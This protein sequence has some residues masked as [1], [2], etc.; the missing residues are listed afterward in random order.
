MTLLVTILSSF[1]VTTRLS[2]DPSPLTVDPTNTPTRRDARATQAI[3]AI[4][5]AY[6]TQDSILEPREEWSI[7]SARQW[8]WP[9]VHD[10]NGDGNVELVVETSDGI[11][12]ANAKSG[13]TIW[14]FDFASSGEILSSD[15]A[16][17]DANGDGTSDVIVAITD[18]PQDKDRLVCINGGTGEL[19]WQKQNG[20][21]ITLVAAYDIMGDADYELLVG[22]GNLSC[23]DVS[24]GSV[25]WT[26]LSGVWLYGN[27]VISD[28][29]GDGWT[30]IYVPTENNLYCLGYDGSVKWSASGG[31]HV[32]QGVFLAD[33]DEDGEPELYMLSDEIEVRRPSSGALVWSI[34]CEASAIVPGDVDGDGHLEVIASSSKTVYCY[35]LDDRGSLL[36]SRRLTNK[37][38][39]PTIVDVDGDGD[40]DVVV[41]ESD[42]SHVRALDGRSGEVLWDLNDYFGIPRSVVVAPRGPSENE[43]YFYLLAPTSSDGLV[44]L[45]PAT[46]GRRVFWQNPGGVFDC[47]PLRD[48]S[49]IDADG[50]MMSARSEVTYGTDLLDADTDDD[51]LPDGWEVSNQLDPLN[52]SDAGDDPDGDGLANIFEYGNCTDPTD[53]DTDNDGMP[54]GW[55]LSNRLD[56]LN[57]EDANDDNDEDELTNLEEYQLGTNPHSWDTDGDLMSDS[58]EVANNLNPLVDDS[59]D[60]PDNDGATNGDEYIAGTDP[61]DSDTDDDGLLDGWEMQYVGLDPLQPGQGDED[62]DSDGLTNLQ[63]QDA[64]TNPNR[65]DTDNDHC[66]DGWE[67]AHDLDPLDP[68]DGAEDTDSDGLINSLEY[69]YG[70]DPRD[71]DTD[72]DTMPDGWEVQ[73]GLDPT[74]PTV[75]DADGDMLDDSQEFALGSLPN[76]SDTDGDFAPDGLE[77]MISLSPTNPND[78]RI[79]MGILVVVMIGVVWK[80]RR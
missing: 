18:Q 56:P 68:D 40:L 3:P 59:T 37:A 74:D 14:T 10:L 46:Y 16:M 58:W 70:T 27:P 65:P 49:A 34:D 6:A 73:F 29:N 75:G 52:A 11:L 30:E 72:G 61:H 24:D 21:Q 76:C 48:T 2:T 78:F 5:S 1:L 19:L 7:D 31:G 50:D 4:S 63:E 41:A 69:D 43:D 13:S 62:S 22:S 35:N 64:G 39:V 42:G 71:A 9:V 77:A 20:D 55:E 17:A 79:V 26:A 45:N 28:F 12:C 51:G 47:L 25:L 23:L 44:C 33:G 32:P 67:I 36:W 66:P 60:D 57:A 8:Y 53:P 80:R 15:I 54:D 38:S